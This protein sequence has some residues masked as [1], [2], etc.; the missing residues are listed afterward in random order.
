MFQQMQAMAQKQ[1]IIVF[2]MCCMSAN[3]QR[4]Q[5]RS[6]VTYLDESMKELES[7]SFLTMWMFP[8]F[9][10]LEVYCARHFAFLCILAL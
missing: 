5:F 3:R 1:V 4:F 6:N 10:D 9:N 8:A 2:Y 7:L